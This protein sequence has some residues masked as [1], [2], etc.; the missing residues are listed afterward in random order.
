[1][2]Y[3]NTISQ[4]GLPSIPITE[5]TSEIQG[6]RV[7]N[8]FSDEC[9]VFLKCI[10]DLNVASNDKNHLMHIPVTIFDI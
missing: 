7:E 5:N 6:I 10:D 3:M 1:M 9:N 4:Y 2:C 8:S